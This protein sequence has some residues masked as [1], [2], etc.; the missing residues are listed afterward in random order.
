MTTTPDFRRG[1]EAAAEA[2][3]S[4]GGPR[5][6]RFFSLGDGETAIL[7]LLTDNPDWI[8]VDQHSS[9]PTKPK[10]ADWGDRSWPE[11]MTAVCRKDKAFGGIY[12]DCYACNLTG[13]NKWGGKLSK[14]TIRVWALA[15]V[16]E[17]V[18]GDGTEEMGG[19][20][21]KGK[22]IGC[23]DKMVEVEVHDKDGKATG[24]KR[25]E[26][27]YVILNFADKNFFAPFSAFYAT[28]G[29]VCDR[30]YVIRR[31]GKDKDTTYNPVP[32]DPTPNLAP[33]TER[34]KEKYLD[35]MA[36]K[37]IDLAKIVASKADDEYF[38]LFLDPG[39]SAPSR[40]KG[41]DSDEGQGDVPAPQV[42]ADEEA[43]IQALKDR[44]KSTRAADVD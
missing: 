14:T 21:K 18:L 34:W 4:K 5:G 12:S 29:T 1:G 8:F 9:I 15:V 24:E 37:G 41:D 26:R 2:S 13:T 39:K 6:A 44:V 33:G 31:T 43:R 28:Y 42:D 3:K 36:E 30:D 23:Q 17:E 16:R 38:A 35:D 20:E 10:P 40:N 27:E 19:P 25:L 32:M 7:R 11:S 22:R